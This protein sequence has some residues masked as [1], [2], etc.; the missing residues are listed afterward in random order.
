MQFKP[1]LFKGQPLHSNST[2]SKSNC[3]LSSHA[4]GPSA[5][6]LSG[7]SVFLLPSGWAANPAVLAVLILTC[8]Q[9]S[10]SRSPPSPKSLPCADEVHTTDTYHY[11][12]SLSLFSS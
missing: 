5:L 8:L 1:V 4:D 12:L 11:S 3:S 7:P 6:A 2:F 10:V 9:F